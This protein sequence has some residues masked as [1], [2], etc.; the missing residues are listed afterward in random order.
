MN[1]T[2][3]TWKITAVLSFCIHRISRCVASIGL[4][5]SLSMI[6]QVILY[7]RPDASPKIDCSEWKHSHRVFRHNNRVDRDW[8]SHW[9]QGATPPRGERDCTP[10]VWWSERT[11]TKGWSPTPTAATTKIAYRPSDLETVV[12]PVHDESPQ[13]PILY[14][15]L[16]IARIPWGKSWYC[17]WRYV[18]LLISSS[19]PL[20]NLFQNYV[21]NTSGCLA[22]SDG[23][24]DIFHDQL[25]LGLFE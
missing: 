8:Y 18:M 24:L 14:P 11:E 13:A 20:L 17:Y 22:V 6:G 2:P 15:K 4:T 23:E 12:W 9:I 16:H 7:S 21:H 10:D 19:N 1:T 5:P 25:F 3:C